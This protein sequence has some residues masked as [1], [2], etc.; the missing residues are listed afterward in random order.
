MVDTDLIKANYASMTNEQLIAL[1]K[2]EGNDISHA[3]FI[4]LKREFRKRALSTELMTEIETKRN[5][6][7]KEKILSRI[8]KEFYQSL[9]ELWTAVIQLKYEDRSDD[10]VRQYL[11]DEGSSYEQAQAFVTDLENI[12]KHLLTITKSQINNCMFA[13]L[14]SIL[15]LAWNYFSFISIITV[16]VSLFIFFSSAVTWAKLDGRKNKFQTVL[17]KITA[18]ART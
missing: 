4:V 9:G 14:A 15:L 13:F 1:A 5:E 17:K 6:F 8:E 2:E 3:A 7:G 16:G 12:L 10:E 11:I 18:E